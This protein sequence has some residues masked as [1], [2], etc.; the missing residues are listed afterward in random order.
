MI[1]LAERQR[2]RKIA[3]RKT[4]IVNQLYKLGIYHT[5]NGSDVEQASLSDLEQIYI[6]E[7]CRAGKAL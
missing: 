3:S 5:R 7:M 2:L 1:D 6:N 4:F